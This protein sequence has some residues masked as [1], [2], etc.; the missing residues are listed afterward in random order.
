MAV[1]LSAN[2]RALLSKRT[3]QPNLI[4]EIDGVDNIYSALEI[5]TLSYYGDAGLVYGMPGIFYGGGNA[6]VKPYI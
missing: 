2:A 6:G 4:I 1:N 3:L 5:I